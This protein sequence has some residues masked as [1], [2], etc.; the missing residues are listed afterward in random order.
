MVKIKAAN[1]EKK[2]EK[3]RLTA[4]VD[5]QT[6]E[7]KLTHT[8]TL[9]LLEDINSENEARK[10]SEQALKESE[11]LFSGIFY[12]SPIPV[13]LSEFSSEKWIAVNEAFL[14]VTE[15]SRD[16][17]IGHTFSEINL[18]KNLKD[19]EVL[20]RNLLKEGH[21]SNFE[22]KINKKYSGLGVILISVEKVELAGQPYLL[23]IGTEITERIKA[24]AK[25]FHAD[26]MT[27]LGEMASGI[28]HEINQPLNIISLVM[29]KILLISEGK[30]TID[31]SFF[32]ENSFKIFD[33]IDRIKNI[34][35]HIRAFS[36]NHDDYILTAFDINFSIENAV[37]LI[38]DQFKQLSINLNLDLEKPIP[39]IVGNTYKFEQVI[40]NLLS[41]ARDAVVER[42]R[43]NV[44][45]FDM[46]V[47]I[48][49]FVE[50]ELLIVEVTD[51]GIGIRNEDINNVILPFY[52]TKDTG[53]G[54]GLGLSICYQIIHEI[55]GRMEITSDQMNETKIKIL[56][57]IKHSK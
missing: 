26:R 40:V 55:N 5:L 6:H 57:E 25:Q 21:V 12:S 53:K 34:I 11:A 37:S 38:I 27:K 1:T 39:K 9:N 41:N 49:S 31:S 48:K 56:F 7:L 54:T 36:S 13:S 3:E 51:N 17:I 46:T 33:N 23:I 52:T 45:T 10:K 15:F 44:E 50:N 22:V 2:Q 32:K 20:R 35:D 8:A 47:G 30:E 24:Q 19:R 43:K 28:A 4:L 16:E 14:K 42:K 18:W 29:D